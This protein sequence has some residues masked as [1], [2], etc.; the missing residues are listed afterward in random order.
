[1]DEFNTWGY[2]VV[3][4]F[5]RDGKTTKEPEAGFSKNPATFSSFL[6]KVFWI[7]FLQYLSSEAPSNEL[8][9]KVGQN[10][11]ISDQAAT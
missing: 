1:M 11:P 4:K 6:P 5:Y 9:I 7:I 3:K 2:F 10:L 8:L